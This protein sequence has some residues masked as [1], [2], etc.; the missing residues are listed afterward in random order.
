MNQSQ[1]VPALASAYGLSRAGLQRHQA[2]HLKVSVQAL[3][4]SN[5]LL[6]IVKWAVDLR[7]R[8]NALC[9]RAETMLEEEG[10]TPKGLQATASSLRELRQI[11]ELLSRLVTTEPD[12]SEADSRNDALDAMI[13]A[14][15]A[16]MGLPELPPG[17]Q[18]IPDADIIEEPDDEA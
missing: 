2:N 10:T 8:A 3:A 15:L 18:D 12:K 6:T 1:T 5:N 13:E 14:Q 11:I 4:E 9:T 7:E 17:N 16:V